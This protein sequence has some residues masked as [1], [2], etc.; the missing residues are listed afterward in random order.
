MALK[1]SFLSPGE[2]YKIC[3]FT[4]CLDGTLLFSLTFNKLAQLNLGSVT[5]LIG[6]TNRQ[7]Y[8]P[9]LHVLVGIVPSVVLE[10]ITLFTINQEFL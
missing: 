7:A 5:E 6:L 1:H 4:S 2:I 8:K 10:V 3:G 9:D